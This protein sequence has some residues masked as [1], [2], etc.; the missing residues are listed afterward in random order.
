M[1]Q[2]IK[3]GMPPSRRPESHLQKPQANERLWIHSSL[4]EI[5]FDWGRPPENPGYR[6]KELNLEK[7]QGSLC[8]SEQAN[9]TPIK[10]SGPSNSASQNASVA[11]S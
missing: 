4:T 8:V 2:R 9:E 6:Y 5:R 7:L 1:V 11:V 10:M 3:N